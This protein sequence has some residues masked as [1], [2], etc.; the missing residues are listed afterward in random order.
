[1]IKITSSLLA[2]MALNGGPSGPIHESESNDRLEAADYLG[3]LSAH[4]QLKAVGSIGHRFDIDSFRFEVREPVAIDITVLTA[5]A[6]LP[7]GVA[8]RGAATPDPGFLPLVLL[9]D[10]HGQLIFWHQADLPNLLI[11]GL[12]LPSGEDWFT[13]QLI[14]GTGAQGSYWLTLAAQ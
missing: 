1:M 12:S 8:A 11:I 9:F 6:T 4:Q 14:S 7:A 13:L 3:A 2:V 10:S 5:A